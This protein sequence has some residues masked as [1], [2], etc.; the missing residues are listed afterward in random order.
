MMMP[1]N[2]RTGKAIVS[3]QCVM[4]HWTLVEDES[5]GHQR[6]SNVQQTAVQIFLS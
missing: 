4:P 5:F 2:R 1:L 3:G 6:L